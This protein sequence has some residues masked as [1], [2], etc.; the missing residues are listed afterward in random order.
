[1]DA[2]ARYAR[3]GRVRADP[4]GPFV[5]RRFG[6]TANIAVSAAYIQEARAAA[7]AQRAA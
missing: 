1:M 3:R 2:K 5:G 4:P 7:L 6:M